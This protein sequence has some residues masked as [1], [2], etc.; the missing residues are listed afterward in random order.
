MRIY[1]NPIAKTLKSCV[2]TLRL[3]LMMLMRDQT[4]NNRETKMG[5]RKGNL[6]AGALASLIGA[7][8]G[9]AIYARPEGLKVPAWVGYAAAAAFVLAGF[10]IFA[11][12]TGRVRLHAWLVVAVLVAMFTP[13]AWI[14]FGPGE[15]ACKLAGN[16]ADIAASGFLCR[17]AFGIGA[18]ILAFMMII[19]FR[20]ARNS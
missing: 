2:L 5:D 7:V 19:A 17:S 18:V 9:I 14:A 4:R 16:Y 12:E 10:I 1:R 6:L 13:G 15:R 11:V 8:A 20:A 3:T